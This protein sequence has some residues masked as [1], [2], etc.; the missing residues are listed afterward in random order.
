M[1]V[2][3]IR[4]L[5]T[6]TLLKLYCCCPEAAWLFFFGWI[7]ETTWMRRALCFSSGPFSVFVISA[8]F[9]GVGLVGKGGSLVSRCMV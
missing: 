1:A 4:E 8:S 7:S 2:V 3:N 5:Q 9:V 6:D